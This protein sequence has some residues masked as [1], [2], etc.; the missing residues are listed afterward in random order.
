M[1]RTVAVIFVLLA[2]ARASVQ[3]AVSPG[4]GSAPIPDLEH[5]LERLDPS[6]PETYFL[7]AEEVAAEM[8]HREGQEL[9]QHLYVLCFELTRGTGSRLAASACLA[10]A[11]LARLERDQRWLLAL[12]RAVGPHD[13]S[14]N[15]SP[16]V[17]PAAPDQLAFELAEAIGLVRAGEGIR[18]QASLDR[19]DVEALLVRYERLLSSTGARGAVD[20]IERYAH[21]WP[22][23]ECHN[24]RYVMS[25]NTDPPSPRLCFVCGGDPGPE[26]TTD[27]LISHLRFESRM[28]SGLQRS[29]AAQIAVDHG[30]VLRDPDPSELAPTYGV[31]PGRPCWRAG[32]WVEAPQGPRSQA[33]R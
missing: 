25:R 9:A 20:R 12:A 3:D 19:E 27:E 11:D 33:R 7:L 23:P 15:W 5:R 18:A 24:R 8:P 22:C 30:A 6:N 4:A 28:L 14:P 26:M 10:L 17:E 29:W 13:D 31:D 21:Q 32:R 2:S 16:T 1:R